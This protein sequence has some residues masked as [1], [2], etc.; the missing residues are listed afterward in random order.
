MKKFFLLT[1]MISLS[2]GYK[3]GDSIENDVATSL[4]IDPTKIVVVDFFA[5]WCHS[6]KKEIPLI[7]KLNMRINKNIIDIIGIDVDRKLQ[8]GLDF[9]ASLKAN[10]SLNFRV[11]NDTN[12]KIIT[13]FKPIGM[14]ALYIIKE[15]KVVDLIYGAVDNIDSTLLRKLEQLQ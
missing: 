12:S 5:S 7:A 14:P 4:G 9:Q 2:F 13:K 11:I 6:C 3:V 10:N 8:D 1:L 15:N